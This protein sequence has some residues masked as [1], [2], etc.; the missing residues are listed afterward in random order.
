MMQYGGKVKG[1]ALKSHKNFIL[2]KEGEEGLEKVRKKMEEI[3]Y[4]VNFDKINIYEWYSCS[5]VMLVFLAAK[6]I[7][8]WDDSV[9][10]ESGSFV[11][12]NSFILR[13]FLK[14]FVSPE[15]LIEMLPRYWEKSYNFGQLEVEEINKEKGYALFR[16]KGYKIHPLNCVA[17]S[18]MGRDM[19]SYVLRKKETKIEE[20]RCM[21]R[22]D[23]YHEYIVRWK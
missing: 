7:F 16:I 15:K 12:K 18:A 21:H 2:Y 5:H 9:V 3:G 1:D 23:D 14:Y 8:E 6:D 17:F 4:P 20:T 19:F 10:E 13:T 11:F 22:G